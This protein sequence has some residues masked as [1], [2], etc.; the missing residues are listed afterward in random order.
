M[1]EEKAAAEA[2]SAIDGVDDKLILQQNDRVE[3]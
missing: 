3:H 1:W 2:A